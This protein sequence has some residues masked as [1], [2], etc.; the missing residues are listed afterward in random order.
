MCF[1]YLDGKKWVNTTREERQF[2]AALFGIVRETPN[3]FIQLLKQSAKPVRGNTTANITFNERTEWEVGFEVA[4]GRD[5]SNQAFH[6]LG[7][8]RKFDLVFFS[9]NHLVVVEAKAQQGF[10]SKEMN[11]YKSDKCQLKSASDVD[12]TFVGICSEH[13]YD[14]HRIDLSVGLDY[15]LTWSK[16]AGRWPDEHFYRA[17]CIYGK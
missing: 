9:K 6:I 4:L 7:S 2:C 11:R 15:I 17:E 16:I 10:S 3:Q 8:S 5:T 13:Y 1:K 14:N 12:V